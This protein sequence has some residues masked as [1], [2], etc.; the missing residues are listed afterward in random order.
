M[1]YSRICSPRYRV[2][3]TARGRGRGQQCPGGGSRDAAAA[4]P[5]RQPRTGT[6]PR[7]GRRHRSSGS[8]WGGSRAGHG[9][10]EP[11]LTRHR[12]V[13]VGTLFLPV[14]GHAGN[15]AP[16][17]FSVPAPGLLD[18]VVGNPQEKHDSCWDRAL[19]GDPG[20]AGHRSVPFHSAIAPRGR[21]TLRTAATASPRIC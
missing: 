6:A 20:Q 16:A 7:A 12:S 14:R 18:F 11:A 21:L 1:H 13:R 5:H 8:P 2:S 17:V 10:L 19:G 4:G 9:P 15:A 3:V